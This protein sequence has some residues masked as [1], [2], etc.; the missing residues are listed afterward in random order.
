MPDASI[1][2]TEIPQAQ[3]LR[4]S[5]TEAL[6]TAVIVGDLEEGQLYSAPTLAALLGVSATPVREAMMDL[7]RE[8][9]VTTAKNKGFRVTEMTPA[10]LEQQTQVRQL[11]EAPAMRAVAGLIPEDDYPGLTAIATEVEEAAKRSDLRT[12]L[13][14]DLRFHAALLSYTRNER[15]VRLASDLRGQTRL[16]ALHA[17]ADRGQLVDSAREHHTLLRL[18]RDG[19]GE[20]A[21]DLIVLHIGHASKLWAT[22][23]EVV[24]ANHVHVLDLVSRHA[25]SLT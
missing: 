5:V 21:Y 15:L 14:G 7:A 11:L 8:G 24:A 1:P 16:K 10:D 20:G 6:R 23:T 25:G 18:L 3:S 19:D 22:G 17:L 9:L 4:Q 12:Y 2:L 13:M